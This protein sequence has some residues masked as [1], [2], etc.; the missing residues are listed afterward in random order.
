MHHGPHAASVCP[1]TVRPC[2]RAIPRPR[3]S[4]PIPRAAPGS[5]N[6][7]VRAP[8][9]A[10]S[11][12]RAISHW[13]SHPVLAKLH[14]CDAL[15]RGAIQVFDTET[16]R[17]LREYSELC[18]PAVPRDDQLKGKIQAYKCALSVDN[19]LLY[20]IRTCEPTRV[21]CADLSKSNSSQL[22]IAKAFGGLKKTPNRNRP[23]P[24]T[25]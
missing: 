15:G 21:L 18:G 19:N 3:A 22:Y 13:P 11:L 12:K 20:L 9:Q 6:G 25:D 17:F 16:G 1:A 8:R 2:T 10:S 7:A 14:V 24:A 5:V 23:A 4:R